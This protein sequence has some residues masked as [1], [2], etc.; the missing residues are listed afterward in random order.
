[1]L[2]AHRY[3]GPQPSH[4]RDG[5]DQPLGD[6]RLRGW[7]GVRRLAGEHLVQHAAKTVD[8][9]ASI[10]A[11]LARG[12]L[13]TH[14]RRGP[15]GDARLRQPL[16]RGGAHRE[17][18][19]EVRDHGLAFVQQDVLRLDVPMDHVAGVRV[20]EGGSDLPRDPEGI[21]H[22]ELLLAFQLVAERFALDV[23][24]HVIEEPSGVTRIV[25]GEDVRMIQT[26]GDLDLPQKPVGSEPRREL[27][28]EHLDRDRAAV[29]HVAGAVYDGHTTAAQLALDRV[30]VRERGP[31]AGNR[32]AQLTHLGHPTRPAPVSGSAG[33]T[34]PPSRTASP[35]AAPRRR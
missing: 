22:R 32:I 18:D 16:T 34:G 8:V 2:D 28:A 25:Q 10:H 1:M 3:R 15:H 17:C 12:L 23:R 4:G 21:L 14:V 19:P 31:E 27:R 11:P 29:L 5:V 13:R 6:Q 26:R 7:S 33:R 20:P 35:P 24:H 30:A 9:A